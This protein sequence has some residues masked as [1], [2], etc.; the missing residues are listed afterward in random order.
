MGQLLIFFR[1][2]TN[3]V[4][5]VGSIK[6]G[7]IFILFKHIFPTISERLLIVSQ[8]I[9]INGYIDCNQLINNKNRS[10]LKYLGGLLVQTF[11]GKTNLHFVIL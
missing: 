7:L 3:I 10:N 2:Q 1:F 9:T 8:K 11:Q 5:R 6:F 4:I